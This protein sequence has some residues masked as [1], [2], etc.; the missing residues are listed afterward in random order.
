MK[1]WHGTLSPNGVFK[2]FDTSDG[3]TSFALEPDGGR[4]YSLQALVGWVASS[5]LFEVE[6]DT[7]NILDF[8]RPEHVKIVVGYLHRTRFKHYRDSN[9]WEYWISDRGAYQCLEHEEL[10]VQNGFDSVLTSESGWLNIHI[11]QK[12]MVTVRRIHKTDPGDFGQLGEG[13]CKAGWEPSP[14]PLSNFERNS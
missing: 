13:R 4:I 9:T 2:E 11:L 10:L 6:I 3:F 14:P 1:A 5:R 12:S 8:R 7:K